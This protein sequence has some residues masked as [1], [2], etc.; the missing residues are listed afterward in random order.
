MTAIIRGL[1]NFAE[2]QQIIII[3]VHHVNKE[4]LVNNRTDIGSLKGTSDVSQKAD[5][6]ITINGDRDNVRR[7]VQAN[8][9]RDEDNRLMKIMFEFR[10]KT[11]QFVEIPNFELEPNV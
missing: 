4:A 2:A 8:K 3:A 6:V 5:K 10:K 9:S 11:M 1:K 7:V